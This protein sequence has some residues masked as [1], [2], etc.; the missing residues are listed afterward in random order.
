[1]GRGW[2]ANTAVGADDRFPDFARWAADPARARDGLRL[3]QLPS[4]V[5]PKVLT[6]A[7]RLDRA[8]RPTTTPN[9][10][11]TGN[12]LR[13]AVQ[14]ALT[15]DANFP[16]L[17]RLIKA[18]EVSHTT[19]AL[20]PGYGTPMPDRD[21]AVFMATQCNDVRWPHDVRGYAHDVAADRVRHPLT[22]GQPVN[23]TPCAFWHSEPA[24]KPVHITPD[25]PS[26]ILMI[27]NL[28][29]PTTPCFGARHM[30]AALDRRARLVTVDHGGHGVYLANGNA[31]GD[32]AVTEFLTTGH[33]PATDRRCNA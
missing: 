16:W 17:A 6:L 18:A 13:Q 7:D 5:R 15:G 30:R 29:D 26:N 33:R 31:C 2:L 11:L 27:Q 24:D 3:A 9:K 4:E 21:A 20:P 28:R 32:R 14:Q 23:I 22:A 19:P 12:L 25:G 10:P 8:P 1:M